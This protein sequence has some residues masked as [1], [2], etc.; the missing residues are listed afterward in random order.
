MLPD[1]FSP[2]IAR[3]MRS[4]DFRRATAGFLPASRD[5]SLLS[6]LIMLRVL[7]FFQPSSPEPVRK[8]VSCTDA[9]CPAGFDSH[10]TR[11]QTRGFSSYEAAF[12]SLHDAAFRH[13]HR[14]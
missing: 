5:I 12:I 9:A 8:I 2:S 7:T 6:T 3:T 10:F 1:F 13:A 11:G 4:R 14:R